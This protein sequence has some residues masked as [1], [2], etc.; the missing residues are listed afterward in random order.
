MALETPAVAPDDGVEPQIVADSGPDE[1]ESTHIKLRELC[2][3]FHQLQIK[4]VESSVPEH[5]ESLREIAQN[6]VNLC[7]KHFDQVLGEL[8]LSEQSNYNFT[9]PLYI[10]ASLVELIRRYNLYQGAAAYDD[11]QYQQMIMAALSFNLG[12][13]AYER[14]IY[15]SQEE[16]SFD[17]KRQL[18]EHYPQQSGDI[19]KAAGL[20]Q[21]LIQDVVRNHNVASENPSKDAL[22]MRTPFIYAGIAMPQKRLTVQPAI[23]NPSR[24]FARMYAQKELD[25]VYG[26]LFLKLNGLAPIGAI[27]NYENCQ[28]ALVI[29][30]PSDD[31]ISGSTVRILT[32][33]SGVQ[34]SRPGD[35]FAFT[36]T[37]SPLKGVADHHL[38]AW[39]RFSAYVMWQK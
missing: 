21:P 6:L 31:D 7:E 2:S 24:E 27:L 32:N 8:F 26:G 20:D 10:A 22:M 33:R 35:R 4:M 39:I 29:K 9:K 36:E 38:F 18:R 30:G 3:N 14:Q 23:D 12:L 34:L 16:F 5:G 37:P 1:S 19:L 25:S 28:K 15:E 11:D 13:L 17:E